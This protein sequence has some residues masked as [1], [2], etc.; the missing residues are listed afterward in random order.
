MT[1]NDGGGLYDNSG[2]CDTLI[3][4]CNAAIKAVVSGQYI[5][6]CAMMVQITQKIMNLKKG[7]AADLEARD[8]TIH[9]LN[10]MLDHMQQKLTGLPVDNEDD[11]GA[12]NDH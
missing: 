6:F 11:G 10:I 4:D 8:K 5:Q 12:E 1:L 2:L 3:S 9:D 7:I